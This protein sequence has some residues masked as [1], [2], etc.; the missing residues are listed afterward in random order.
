MNEI[1][2]QV[3]SRPLRLAAVEVLLLTLVA[4]FI[5]GLKLIEEPVESFRVAFLAYISQGGLLLVLVDGAR[6]LRHF[7]LVRKITLGSIPHRDLVKF[8]VLRMLRS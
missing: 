4:D 1:L 7:F 5:V 8:V 3:G 2:V 6:N